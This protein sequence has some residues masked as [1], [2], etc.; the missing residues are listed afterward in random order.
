MALGALMVAVIV[1]GYEIFPKNT[2]SPKA[3][4]AA[5]AS[6]VTGVQASSSQVSN[7][8]A[9]NAQCSQDLPNSQTYFEY[10]LV[11]DVRSLHA[12]RFGKEQLG[13]N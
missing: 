9:S 12:H 5:V 3:A 10:K 6:A 2:A 1:F 4:R 8:D 13:S 11:F 7:F